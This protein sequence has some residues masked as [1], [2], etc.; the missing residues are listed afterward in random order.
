MLG[1]NITE[2][3]RC[4]QNTFQIQSLDNHTAFWAQA[5]ATAGFMGTSVRSTGFQGK[6]G[7]H[8]F[9]VSVC[10]G[11]EICQ[12]TGMASFLLE[13]RA[14]GTA[15]WRSANDVCF[16]LSCFCSPHRAS[17]HFLLS[18][19]VQSAQKLFLQHNRL[20][21]GGKKWNRSQCY[22]RRRTNIHQLLLQQGVEL[23]EK[24]FWIGNDHPNP[25]TYS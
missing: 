11:V 13:Y 16:N 23:L 8:P 10:Q 2:G 9:G 25:A 6:D 14:A 7:L 20:C 12:N 19:N 21:K 24:P 18:L 4:L 3:K 1:E 22:H 17:H 15:P 5:A